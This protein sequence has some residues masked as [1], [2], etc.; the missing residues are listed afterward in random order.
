MGEQSIEFIARLLSQATREIPHCDPRQGGNLGEKIKI[1]GMQYT[2]NAWS[3][4]IL[5]VAMTGAIL[6]APADAVPRSGELQLHVIDDATG[7]PLACRMHLKNDRGR[8]RKAPKAPFLVDHFIF[9]SPISLVLREGNYTFEAECGPEYKTRTGHFKMERGG[10][11]TK[12]LR[13]RRFVD[14]AAEGWYAG[15]LYVRR[16]V[17]DIEKLMQAENLAFVQVISWSDTM[18]NWK[19]STDQLTDLRRENRDPQ[20]LFSICAGRDTRASGGLSIFPLADDNTRLPENGFPIDRLR[21][22]HPP[23]VELAQSWQAGEP[24]WIDAESPDTRDLP[25]WVA[26]GLVNSVRLAHHRYTRAGLKKEPPTPPSCVPRDQDQYPGVNGLGH[27][28]ETIYYRLLESGLRIVPT[29]GSG[30]GDVGNPIGH[31]RVY[32]YLGSDTPMTKDAWWEGLRKGQVMVTNGP[33]LRVLVHGQPPGHVFRGNP[34]ETL[35]LEPDIKLSVKERVDYLEIVKNGRVIRA[36]NLGKGAGGELPPI[37]FEQS[38]WFLV[39]VRASSN[40]THRFATTGP[41]YVEFETPRISQTAT[42]FFGQWLAKQAVK[43]AQ[44]DPENW[45]KLQPYYEQAAV[46]WKQRATAATVD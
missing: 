15:D 9:E 34:G 12:T 35:R 39:R 23:A 43:L 10:T 42:N 30:S 1:Y 18:N 11:D 33:M 16:P 31:N 17:R 14:M 45:Q 19:R 44:E 27:W 38:G 20:L 2:G 29:A 32:V 37:T 6:P 5:S 26:H 8:P 36:V 7:K 21:E 28:C 3:Q 24:V 25:V 22:D 46:F 13:M 41:F 4:L 40:Q